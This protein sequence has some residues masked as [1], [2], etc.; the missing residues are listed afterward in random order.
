MS[1]VYNES[2]AQQSNVQ[3]EPK[4]QMYFVSVKII[5]GDYEKHVTSFRMAESEEDAQYDALCGECHNE[6]LSREA[7]DN[8]EEFWDDYMVLTPDFARLVPDELAQHLHEF[9][10]QQYIVFQ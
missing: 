2:V 9:H 6:P 8:H 4:K 7:Y 1:H 10:K 3:I 5:L